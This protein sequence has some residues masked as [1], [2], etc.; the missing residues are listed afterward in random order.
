VKREVFPEFTQRR[1]ASNRREARL[2]AS[3]LADVRAGALAWRKSRLTELSLHGF[4]LSWLPNATVGRSVTVRMP[5]IEPLRAT[6]RH[7]DRDGVGCEFERPLS[8]Y[9]LEHLARR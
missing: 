9:V 4:K 2:P 3:I 5:G 1:P 8:P 6:I 7:I